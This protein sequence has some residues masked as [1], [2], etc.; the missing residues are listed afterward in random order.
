MLR[1]FVCVLWIPELA[2]AAWL[3]STAVHAWVMHDHDCPGRN[4]TAVATAGAGG[5]MEARPLD[6]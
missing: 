2:R 4:A 3:C 6:Y 1:V 5:V